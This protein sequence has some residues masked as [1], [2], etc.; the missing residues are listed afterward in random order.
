MLL[1]LRRRDSAVRNGLDRGLDPTG[2]ADKIEA[3]FRLAIPDA[4][5]LSRLAGLSRLRAEAAS[6][7]FTL[8]KTAHT[9]TTEAARDIVRAKATA[10]SYANRWLR[11][12]TGDKTAQAAANASSVT[13]GSVARIG[14]TENAEAFSG[15][16][17]AALENVK[18]PG[19]LRVWDS[20]LDKA[21]CP[22]CRGAEGTIV[23]IREPFPIGE[24][25]ATH[26]W[27]RCN[28][29]LLTETEADGLTTIQ[30]A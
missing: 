13:K 16:R 7:G 3:V 19:L 2:I 24:P 23:G 26:P 22:V 18:R 25:G 20:T 21:T 12:A 9:L 29:T 8:A 17:K 10:T 5:E 11:N 6:V 28:W 15:G 27:C 1:L 14:A 30:A 4:R